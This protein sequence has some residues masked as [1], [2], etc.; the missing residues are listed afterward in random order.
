MG[1]E[2]ASKHNGL[3]IGNTDTIRSFLRS[4]ST[5]PHLSADLQLTASTLA[6]QTTLPYK[7]L[8]A[9]WFASPSQTRPKLSRLSMDP[10]SSSPAP[11]PERR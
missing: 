9:L 4:A 8:R 7:P 5:D 11:N 10:N 1:E 3:I 2:E 6:S